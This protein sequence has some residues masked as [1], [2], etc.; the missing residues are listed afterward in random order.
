MKPTQQNAKQ[1]Q[2]YTFA[3]AF[4]RKRK[5]FIKIGMVGE[6]GRIGVV[7][8]MTVSKDKSEIEIEIDLLC[9]IAISQRATDGS[10][11]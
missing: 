4:A 7:G 8:D 6:V 5:I 10:G 3:F 1:R 9:D 11:G 2:R